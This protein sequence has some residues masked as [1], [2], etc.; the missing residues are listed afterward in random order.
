MVY[1]VDDL[2]HVGVS[3]FRIMVVIWVK[4]LICMV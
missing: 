2:L 3:L 4:S 1:A